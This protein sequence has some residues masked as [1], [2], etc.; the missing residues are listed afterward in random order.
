M[1][2]W[3]GRRYQQ[4]LFWP[5]LSYDLDQSE[6]RLQTIQQLADRYNIHVR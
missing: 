2:L 4:P 3:G 6:W 5:V 1:D